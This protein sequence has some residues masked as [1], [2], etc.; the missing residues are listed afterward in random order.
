MT[1]C[2]RVFA[3]LRRIFRYYPR[4]GLLVWK[5]NSEDWWDMTHRVGNDAV[6][7]SPQGPIVVLDGQG[8]WAESI[9]WAI[10]GDRWD[11][12]E[13]VDPEKG[14]VVTNLRVAGPASHEPP[15]PDETPKAPGY[16]IDGL[17]WGSQERF[18][19]AVKEGR[20]AQRAIAKGRLSYFE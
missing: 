19:R 2:T 20:Q 1:A 10:Y 13:M 12:V 11:D 3:R 6:M 17:D 5:T 16:V 14:L 18:E 4:H 15:S 9:C 8:Y 7:M